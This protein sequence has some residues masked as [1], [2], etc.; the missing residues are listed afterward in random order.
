MYCPGASDAGSLNVQELS[1]AEIWPGAHIPA[2]S[3]T[4]AL[5]CARAFLAVPRPARVEASVIDLDPRLG[6][7][8]HEVGAV[9]AAFRQTDP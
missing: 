4:A 9:A 6:G 3:A 1:A 7:A 2:R 8:G 5:Q